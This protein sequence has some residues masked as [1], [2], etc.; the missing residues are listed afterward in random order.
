MNP[1]LR[2]RIFVTILFF[3]I[4][5]F[6]NILLSNIERFIKLTNFKDRFL[7]DGKRARI[8]LQDAIFRQYLVR[9]SVY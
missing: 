3:Y 2:T 5:L 4:S 7:E 6:L 9:L 1:N 8:G